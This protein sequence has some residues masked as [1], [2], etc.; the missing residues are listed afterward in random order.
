MSC[1]LTCKEHG[2]GVALIVCEHVRDS[3]GN[4]VKIDNKKHMIVEK[5]FGVRLCLSCFSAY[6]PK[7]LDGIDENADE[8]N[9]HPIC[10]KCFIATQG[11]L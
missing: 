10:V 2:G 3:V 5:Y 7:L 8:L 11:L 4:K 6:Q 1:W 9:L